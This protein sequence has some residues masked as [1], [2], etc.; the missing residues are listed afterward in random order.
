[1]VALEAV[2]LLVLLLVS[3]FAPGFF[4][5]R[6]LPWSP[7]E[8]LCGSVGLSLAL[9]YLASWG[10]YCWA[11]G[12]GPIDIL[13]YAGVT[14]A[15]AGLGWASRRDI[16]RLF[17]TPRVRRIVLGYAFLLGWSLLLFGIIRSYAGASWSAD[18]L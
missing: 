17:R 11:P 1:V 10:I 14:L 6:R 18:W 7:A 13:P 9:L 12:A 2:F 4:I 5:L 8:K 3:S 16:V 15:A